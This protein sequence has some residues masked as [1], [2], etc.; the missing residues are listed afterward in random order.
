MFAG[1]G[2]PISAAAEEETLDADAEP[3]RIKLAAASTGSAGVSLL[4]PAGDAEL[5]GVVAL[6]AAA[7][8]PGGRILWVDF[9]VD[10]AVVGSSAVAPYTFVLDVSRLPAGAHRFQ[11]AAW[12]D[13]VA[14]TLSGTAAA[15]TSAEPPA[16]LQVTTAAG[17][18]AA[19]GKLGAEGGTISLAAGTYALDEPLSVGPRVFLTGA[20]RGATVLKPASSGWSRA[21]IRLTGSGSTLRSLSIDY[22]GGTWNA[23]E[24][25]ADQTGHIVLQDLEVRGLRSARSG[26]ELWGKAHRDV[27][28]Q[29]CSFDGGGGGSAGIRDSAYDD[30]SG[31]DSAFRNRVS[32]FRELGIAFPAWSG[33]KPVV[34]A[35]NLAVGN[36]IS[37]I[38]EGG[39][40][41]GKSEA[42]LWLGG[43]DNVAFRNTLAR[44]GW[45]L[46]WLGSNCFRCRVEENSLSGSRTGVYLEHSADDAV[47]KDNRISGVDTGVNVE[48][49]YGGAGTRRGRL[50]GN[51]IAARRI[52]IALD[53]G[54]DGF[55]IE[56]N[57]I[58]SDELAI[59]LSGVSGTVVRGNDLRPG[60]AA[61]THC[62]A[63]RPA[64][65]DKGKLTLSDH[66]TV[67]GND[68]RGSSEGIVRREGASGAHDTEAGNRW[69]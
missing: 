68:C 26:V 53:V 2:G 9:L 5:S 32:G 69:P 43:Q 45:E 6:R 57:S 18:A 21:L 14:R 27:S 3:G 24:A 19:L 63:E 28:V 49:T 47:V 54:S 41:D 10:G 1:C 23:I 36:E 58:R 62:I 65:S 56:R 11:A 4:E 48:W 42:A 33:G 30:L 67:V 13:G 22:E 37:D 61:Q 51:T 55:V 35:R 12:D 64:R 50:A 52:G 39:K 59:R 29:D 16:G 40:S 17:L 60:G 15:R 46:V 44:S 31:D 25:P 66:T 7:S 20:G 8:S 34:S 38:G